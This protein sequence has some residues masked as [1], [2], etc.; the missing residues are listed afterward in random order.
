MHIAHVN[1]ANMGS[2]VAGHEKQDPVYVLGRKPDYILATW[3]DY[4]SSIAAEIKAAYGYETVDSPTG[5][6]VKWLRRNDAKGP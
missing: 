5:T 4:F 3:E 2:E 1:V 6:P